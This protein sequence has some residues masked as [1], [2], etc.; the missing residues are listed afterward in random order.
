[1]LSLKPKVNEII[2]LTDSDTGNVVARRKPYH[3]SGGH[4]KLAFDIPK[5][6]AVTREKKTKLRKDSQ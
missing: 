1:M 6:I 4:L 5:K 2:V 3:K